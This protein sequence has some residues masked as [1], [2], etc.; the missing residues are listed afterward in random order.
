MRGRNKETGD[1]LYRI[2]PLNGLVDLAWRRESWEGHLECDWAQ[3]QNRVAD[4]V[5]ET[6]SPGYAVFNLRFAKTF[7]KT[8]RVEVG[9]ENLMDKRYADH[10]GG[11]NRVTG[12]D[13]AT[14]ERIPSAG[15]FAY[16]SVTWEF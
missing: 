2:A 8:L 5:G 9:V 3:A 13:L 14:G 7:M 4:S 15:R 1:D 6:R 11:V 12:G 16:T 10:L